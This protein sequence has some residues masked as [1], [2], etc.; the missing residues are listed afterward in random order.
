V[1]AGILPGVEGQLL[2]KR[3]IHEHRLL[4]LAPVEL[5]LGVPCGAEGA[6][7]SRGR[8]RIRRSQTDALNGVH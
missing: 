4:N 6:Q 1:A 7:S 3:A 8:F 5:A 2:K